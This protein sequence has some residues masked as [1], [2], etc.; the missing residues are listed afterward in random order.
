MFKLFKT[1]DDIQITLLTKAQKVVLKRLR[2]LRKGKRVG[3]KYFTE[4]YLKTSSRTLKV[5]LDTGMIESGELK[6]R[7]V[8]T[9][10]NHNVKTYRAKVDPQ[11]F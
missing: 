9:R 10:V 3:D 6:W 5:L 4:K 11:T 2:R 1:L 7:N 8:R